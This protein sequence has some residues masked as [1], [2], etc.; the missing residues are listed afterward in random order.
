MEKKRIITII[1]AIIL[2]GII[3][4]AYGVMFGSSHSETKYIYENKTSSCTVI[5]NIECKCEYPE[6]EEVDCL[7]EYSEMIATVEDYKMITIGGLEWKY[8]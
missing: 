2:L 6:V 5:R 3:C 1:S 8:K 4:F 7:A